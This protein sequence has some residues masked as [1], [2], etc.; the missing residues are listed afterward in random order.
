MDTV[1]DPLIEQIIICESGET[2]DAVK[3]LSKNRRDLALLRAEFEDAIKNG[4]P[5]ARCAACHQP[6]KPRLSTL[7]HQFFRHHEGDGNCPYKTSG[8]HDQKAIDA[9]KYNGQKEGVDHR[10]VKELLEKS[11]RADI[12][13]DPNKIATEKRWW[14]IVDEK[15]WRRPDVTAWNSGTPIRLLKN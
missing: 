8:G 9:M 13:F 2:M 6:V 3:F 5:I 10:Y 7:R 11:I 1:V 12:R 15:K 14:G 4:S